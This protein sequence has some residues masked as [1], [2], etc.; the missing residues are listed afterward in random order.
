MFDLLLLLLCYRL[1]HK[2]DCTPRAL[3]THSIPFGV[4]SFHFG[5]PVIYYI[6]HDAV[7]LRWMLYIYCDDGVQS[8]RYAWWLLWC[9]FEKYCIQTLF[10]PKNLFLQ[11]FPLY[12]SHSFPCDP[13]FRFDAP[14]WCVS[15]CCRLPLK[16]CTVHVTHVS[17][18]WSP[19]E[20]R[21][22]LWQL[23]LS[24]N[25][26]TPY[27]SIPFNAFRHI[28]RLSVN[29]ITVCDDHIPF[30]FPF[31]C[32]L[33]Y[34]SMS[35]WKTHFVRDCMQR[36]HRIRNKNPSKLMPNYPFSVCSYRIR[37]GCEAF[38]FHTWRFHAVATNH[39]CI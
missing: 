9:A 17:F 36:S 37:I 5:S 24:L 25:S 11:L 34:K 28:F 6:V 31:L 35:Q 18:E 4:V 38:N 15:T 8:N 20:C 3:H 26:G 7:S 19:V 1:S 30:P 12:L 23:I 2:S 22:R 39:F 32:I 14:R 29:I 16:I 10:V 27:L 13:S 21:C 33:A